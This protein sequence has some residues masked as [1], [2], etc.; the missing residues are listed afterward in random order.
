MR[1]KILLTGKDE[2]QQQ[3]DAE[4][5][6]Q[7]GF[8][9]YRCGENVVGDM[10]D[11]IHPDVVIVNPIEKDNT[12]S[13]TL[14]EKLL[15]NIKYARLP[16]IYTLSED[17]VYLVNRR[18]TATRG[19]RNFIADNIIDGIKTALGFNKDNTRGIPGLNLGMAS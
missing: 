15:N 8:L 3:P 19:K 2:Q 13:S 12:T 1:L 16:L 9:V 6:S 18:R 17:D 10:I 4:L 7:R 11:E 5:L 14:Y